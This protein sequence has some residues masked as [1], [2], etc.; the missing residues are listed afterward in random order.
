MYHIGIVNSDKNANYKRDLGLLANYT[1]PSIMEKP[2][3]TIPTTVETLGDFTY[4]KI[5]GTVLK[6]D[7]VKDS[8]SIRVYETEGLAHLLLVDPIKKGIS[9]NEVLSMALVNHVFP[10]QDEKVGK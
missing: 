1:I 5:N 9:R 3:I 2:M 8:G 4:H 7:M 6:Q 10:K